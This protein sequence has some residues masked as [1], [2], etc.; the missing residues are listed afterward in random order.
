MVTEHEY[1]ETERFFVDIA[2]GCTV[3]VNLDA[4]L[5][6]GIRY[7]ESITGWSLD[8]AYGQARYGNKITFWISNDSL[9]AGYGAGVYLHNL[10]TFLYEGH[11]FVLIHEMTHC[12]EQ[13]QGPYLGQVLTEGHSTYVTKIIAD[14]A[15]LPYFF[16]A[17]A[18]YS[19]FA[20]EI[21][22]DNAQA[23]FLT[24]SGWDA[25]MYGYRL[26]TYLHTQYGADIYQR[27]MEKALAEEIP[28]QEFTPEQLSAILKAV[29]E[30]AVFENFASWYQANL[31]LFNVY[32][33]PIETGRY[34]RII[35]FPTFMDSTEFCSDTLHIQDSLTVDLSIWRD[36]QFK[37]FGQS[38]HTL[39]GTVTIMG[40]GTLDFYDSQ[41]TLLESYS[42][43]DQTF[44]VSLTDV[45]SICITGTDL[46]FTY[47]FTYVE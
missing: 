2:A 13:R 8:A 34:S 32:Q 5:D 25:Y 35:L 46:N 36:Y 42:G 7:A 18:N 43:T 20:Q 44:D 37:Q 23:L 17:G 40:T 28:G 30:D 38:V 10:D 14:Q 22:A 6:Q 27:I 4:L 21:T 31:N 26:S 39:Q 29:T 9:A 11:M 16:D 1:Y 45:N 19:F 41:G 24:L 15:A 33:A 47:N 12:L 3:P